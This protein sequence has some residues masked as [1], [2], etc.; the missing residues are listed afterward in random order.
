MMETRAAAPGGTSRYELFI[1]ARTPCKRVAVPTLMNSAQKKRRA[2]R[3][4]ALW[5]SSQR[6]IE[7]ADGCMDRNAVV[8]RFAWCAAD[9]NSD[10]PLL[11]H[12]VARTTSA[13]GPHSPKASGDAEESRR[14][15]AL[16]RKPAS[17]RVSARR[18]RFL[19]WT[20][21]DVSLQYQLL[22]ACTAARFGCYSQARSYG[23]CIL[24]AT[25]QRQ[26]A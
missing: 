14:P 13:C 21:S 3:L 23:P 25:M 9:L 17:V 1:G 19:P 11:R 18:S 10:H 4:G 26:T 5:R 20:P 16:H 15:P 8:V 24:L 22:T 7:S 2:T 6:R 12:A